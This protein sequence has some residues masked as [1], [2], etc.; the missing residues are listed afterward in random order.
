MKKSNNIVKDISS[1]GSITL[2]VKGNVEN[3]VLTGTKAMATNFEIDVSD[4]PPN[5][6][7][8][9]VV[10]LCA[11]TIT[12][13]PTFTILGWVIPNTIIISPFIALCKY[14]NGAWYVWIHTFAPTAGHG[15]KIDPGTGAISINAKSII[16]SDA[17]DTAAFAFT[18]LVALTAD[19]LP[20][21]NAS[22]FIEAS[23]IPVAK[24]EFIK[25]LASDAQNQINQVI[26]SLADYITATALASALADYYT[27]TQVD[28]ALADYVLTSVLSSYSNTT[29]MNAAIAAGRSVKTYNTPLTNNTT[30][31]ASTITDTVYFDSTGG[32]FTIY[33]PLISSLAD[34]QI[35]TLKQYGANAVTIGANASDSGFIEVAGT[36]ALNL[37]LSS[38][39]GITQ[40]QCNAATKL[41]RVL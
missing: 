9:W 12:D 32:G 40:L 19:M 29:V 17:S 15:I 13:S 25:T 41:W 5:V 34:G 3:L 35:V 26:A 23:D 4:T 14:L 16:A 8:L 6:M 24:A 27:S 28:S 20:K 37:T 36:S 22:G 30:L 38:A 39:G 2:D 18:Q 11:I 7:E 10:N 21:L 33:L 1:I 31:N